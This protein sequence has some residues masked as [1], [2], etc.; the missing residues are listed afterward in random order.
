MANDFYTWKD[1]MVVPGPEDET[2][3]QAYLRY[4]AYK[5]RNGAIDE[6][7]KSVE[8]D[9]AT[10]S[11]MQLKLAKSRAMKKIKAKL[12]LGRKRAMAKTA[13]MGRLK[14]RANKAARLQFF[15]KLT[16]GQSPSDVSPARRIEIEKRLDKMKGRI[17]RVA[18]KM[19]PKIR[20]R[21]Q[22]RRS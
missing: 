10:M 11:A 2:E 5:R 16:K 13:N 7:A 12:K 22:E 17:Q 4:R 3:A 21:E 19:L 6:S 15:K 18:V 8:T 20:Q 14:K 9:E 1:L